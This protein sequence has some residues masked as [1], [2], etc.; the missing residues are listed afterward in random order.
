MR[1]AWLNGLAFFCVFT[2]LGLAQE[3]KTYDLKLKPCLTDRF[4]LRRNEKWREL[5]ASGKKYDRSVS[6]RIIRYWAT[7]KATPKDGKGLECHYS[8][9]GAHDTLPESLAADRDTRSV[10][11]TERGR[12]T[13]DQVYS[14]T[15]LFAITLPTKTVP[16]GST[17]TNEYLTPSHFADRPRE[18]W[19]VTE[20]YRL[21]GKE[22]YRGRRYPRIDYTIK[23]RPKDQKDP[24]AHGV[25]K[26]HVLFCPDDGIVVK[27]EQTRKYWWKRGLGTASPVWTLT[28]IQEQGAL[29]IAESHEEREAGHQPRK[30]GDKAS[31]AP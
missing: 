14:S 1:S 13:K 18:K 27:K 19:L 31:P 26:G 30:A 22:K 8:V 24:I 4:Y 9:Y 6:M 28:T 3:E 11:V 7:S 10:L 15:P 29:L 17:W 23:R 21:V 20:T 12:S 16:I 5:V 2:S 25:T